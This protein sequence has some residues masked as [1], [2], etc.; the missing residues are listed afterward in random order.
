[1]EDAALLVLE[2]EAVPE[3]ADEDPEDFIPTEEVD[4]D[5]VAEPV[6]VVIETEP[7]ETGL[8][9]LTNPES[10]VSLGEAFVD[11]GPVIM[12]VKGDVEVA[13]TLAVEETAAAEPSL[14]P[15]KKL[16][17]YVAVPE[18]SGQPGTVVIGGAIPP[19]Q[20]RKEQISPVPGTYHSTLAPP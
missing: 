3:E 1:L 17:E 5:S 18:Y 4:M 19:P 20:S 11:E 13:A 2:E 8:E 15:G 7:D 14:N 9:E 10:P 12:A 16:G 6:E